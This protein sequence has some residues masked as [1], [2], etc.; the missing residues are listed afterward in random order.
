MTDIAQTKSDDGQGGKTVR[1]ILAVRK[2]VRIE[3]RSGG[4]SHDITV[5]N[6]RHHHQ[7]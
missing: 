6:C 3:V 4:I 1:I 5:V 2:A 7:L